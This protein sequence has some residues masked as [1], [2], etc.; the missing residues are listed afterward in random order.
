MENNTS[1]RNF[2]KKVAILAP[3]IGGLIGGSASLSFARRNPGE[4]R[5]ERTEDETIVD[6]NITYD[7]MV[8]GAT[9]AGVIAAYTAK[10]YGLRVILVEPGRHLGGLSSGGL[11]KT[12][13]GGHEDFITGLAKEFYIRIGQYYGSPEPMYVF[14]PHVAESIFR[15]YMNESDVEIFYSRRVKNVRTENAKIATVTLESATGQSDVITIGATIFIDASYEGD[16]MAKAG[17]SYTIGREDN[18]DYHE[19]FNGVQPSRIAG[20]YTGPVKRTR[21]WPVDIDP[22]VTEG[23]P[24]SGLLPE[25]NGIGHKPIG[26]GDKSI[27]AYCFRLCL[28]QDMDNQIPFDEP[29]RYHPGNYELLARLLTKNPWNSLREGFNIAK[30]PRGKTDWNNNGLAGFSSDYIGQNFAYPDGDYLER[31]R[32]WNDHIDYQKGLLWF[33]ANDERV[34]SHLRQEMNTW[35]YCRDEFLDTNGWPNALYVREAR[36]MVGDFVMTERECVGINPVT[37]GIAYGIYALDSHD[38]QRIAVDGHVENEGNTFI[39]GFDPYLISYRSL[40]PRR[41]EIANL[42]VPACLSATHSAF[43]SIRMEP[44]FMALGQVSGIAAYL[45]VSKNQAI[46]DVSSTLITKELSDNPLP[47]RKLPSEFSNTIPFRHH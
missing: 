12:D 26:S 3:G 13:T 35:G 27:Q 6:R 7:V 33:I 15:Q 34:P 44:V 19:L 30:L 39:N 14:E 17:V 9:S 38:C 18:K 47:D 4:S 37:D 2:V 42:V 36:R 11:G 10:M 32:I 8:Y 45:A 43:C 23:K 29:A 24:S 46:Q 40:V 5:A 28:T 22:Y 1:R 16:L 20:T 41:N 25:I 31:L 21:S